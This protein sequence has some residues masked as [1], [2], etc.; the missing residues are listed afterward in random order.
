MSTCDR[1]LVDL[2][3]MLTLDRV[4]GMEADYNDI[5]QWQYSKFPQALIPEGS[6][7]KVKTWNV[8]TRQE[9]ESLLQDPAFTTGD[10]LQVSAFCA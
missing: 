2:N 5:P 7:H 4:H 10:G 3:T 6:S 8:R 1:A 9:L